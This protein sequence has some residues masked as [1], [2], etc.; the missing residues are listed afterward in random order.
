MS[1][2][3]REKWKKDRN[4]EKGEGKA[5]PHSRHTP[6]S[7]FYEETQ[8]F[9]LKNWNK[10]EK[11]FEENEEKRFNIKLVHLSIYS[12]NSDCVQCGAVPFQR[13]AFICSEKKSNSHDAKQ[14]GGRTASER[15]E[16]LCA[17]WQNHE[18]TRF[19]QYEARASSSSQ[20]NAFFFSIL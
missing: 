8:F 10:L 1:L 9:S 15:T 14:N 16:N 6:K 19:N 3:A 20:T 5:Q 12:T 4:G 2:Y 7:E 17:R 11:V 18:Y 13:V